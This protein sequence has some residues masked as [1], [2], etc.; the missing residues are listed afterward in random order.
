[1]ILFS[2]QLEK[3][4]TLIFV[5]FQV[6]PTHTVSLGG[7]HYAGLVNQELLLLLV[8]ASNGDARVSFL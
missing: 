2:I 7:M 8:V 6:G 3:I 5:D 4:V 1:M